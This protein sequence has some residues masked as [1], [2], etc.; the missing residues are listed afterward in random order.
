M[1]PIKK[2][3][4]LILGISI[5]VLMI[6]F[7]AAS[8]YLP[9][10]YTQPQTNFLYVSDSPHSHINSERYRVY[11]GK[12]AK[13]YVKTTEINMDFK[14]QHTQQLFIH[15]VTENKSQEVS[16]EEAEKLNLDPSTESPDGFEV[17]Y[18]NRNNGFFIFSPGRDYNS[19]YLAGH[20]MSTKLNLVSGNKAYYSEIEFIGWIK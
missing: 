2:N 14:N 13:H 19:R 17:V 6:I 3:I 18:G 12:I 1:K 7:V 8:I 10:L 4:S 11:D 20:N 15:D 16:F 5:P 9:G